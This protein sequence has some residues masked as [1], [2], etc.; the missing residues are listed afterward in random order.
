VIGGWVAMWR[1]LEI[2][3]YD[4]WPILGEKRIRDR[5]SRVDV[6]IVH[7]IPSDRD[8]LS[9]ILA[10]AASAGAPPAAASPT[11]S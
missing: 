4:W 10:G 6:R 5:L 9:R 7:D 3:L 1:P 8:G 2:F 11:R